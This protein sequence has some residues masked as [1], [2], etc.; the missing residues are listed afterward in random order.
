MTNRY[1]INLMGRDQQSSASN[2]NKFLAPGIYSRNISPVGGEISKQLPL[3]S[4]RNGGVSQLVNN[5]LTLNTNKYSGAY[6]ARTGVLQNAA[7]S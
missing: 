5:I 7:S 2:S 1:Q 6:G 3:N 4:R